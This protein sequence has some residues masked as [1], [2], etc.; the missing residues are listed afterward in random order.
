MSSSGSIT[1]W[2]QRLQEGDRAAVERIWKGYYSR[3]VAVARKKLHGL[4]RDMA[5]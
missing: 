5:D 4:P 2:I 1:A 3:L